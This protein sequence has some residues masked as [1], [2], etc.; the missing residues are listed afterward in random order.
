MYFVFWVGWLFLWSI[1]GWVGSWLIVDFCCFIFFVCVDSPKNS[2]GRSHDCP[3]LGRSVGDPHTQ[4]PPEPTFYFQ[5]AVALGPD[6]STPPQWCR[7]QGADVPTSTDPPESKIQHLFT[8]PSEPFDSFLGSS[9]AILDNQSSTEQKYC[10]Q[11]KQS[12][13]E[14]KGMCPS[15]LSS[16]LQI[17]SIP[18]WFE[19]LFFALWNRGRIGCCVRNGNGFVGYCTCLYVKSKRNC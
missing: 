18:E 8:E 19:W 12:S 6:G 15:I 2:P 4:S 10:L 1:V 16:K 5:S 14:E 7:F 17:V 3:I 13:P 11:D 9:V